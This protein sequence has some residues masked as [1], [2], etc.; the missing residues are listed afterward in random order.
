LQEQAV[1]LMLEKLEVV[2]QMFREKPAVD[3]SEAFYNLAA[4]PG[5]PYISK[6]DG[7]RYEEYFDSDTKTRLQIILTAEEHILSLEDGKKRYIDEVSAL[8]KAFALALPHDQAMDA[9]DE[10]AFFQAVKARLVKFEVTSNGRSADEIESVIK[11]VVDQALVSDKVIDVFDAAGIKRP[12]ISILSEEFL[13]EIREMKHQNVAMET[14]KK[15]LNDEIRSRSTRNLVQSKTLMEMLENSIKRYQNK[16]I[17][18]AEV[19]QELI[20]LANEIKKADARGEQMGLSEE[21][22]AFYDAVASNQ[23]ARELMQDEVLRDLAIYLV[24]TVKNNATIDWTIKVNARARL[25][26]MVKRALRKFGYPP[27][28]QKLAT[29]TVLK[30]AE[31][32]AERWVK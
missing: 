25:K 10:I 15:L 18:A 26:V 6:E 22:L 28:Q 3:Y 17:T 5:I 19:I 14:L 21:E 12:D 16:I 1:Q 20:D 4:D 31:M 24:Q 7:L 9:K 27:D 8:S 2:S 29:E 30:Q 23:S 32:L 13:M 11:Q